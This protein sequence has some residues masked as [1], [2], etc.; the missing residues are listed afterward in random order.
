MEGKERGIER[1]GDGEIW[2]GIDEWYCLRMNGS[3]G[4]MDG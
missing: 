2:A 1:E 3:I 4:S